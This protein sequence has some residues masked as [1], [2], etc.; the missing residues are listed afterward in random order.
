MCPGSLCIWNC[1]CD[2]Y[3]FHIRLQLWLEYGD[4][5]LGSPSELLA[6]NVVNECEREDARDGLERGRQ[7]GF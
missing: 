6:Y 3:Q 2:V 1:Q 5:N 7:V 4:P